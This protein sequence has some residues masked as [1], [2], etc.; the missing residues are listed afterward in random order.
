M[1]Q[2]QAQTQGGERDDNT[3]RAAVHEQAPPTPHPTPPSRTHHTHTCA[4][5]QKQTSQ[6]S[7]LPHL[8]PKV[9]QGA[10]CVTFGTFGEGA[11]LAAFQRGTPPH[12]TPHPGARHNNP[13]KSAAEVAKHQAEWGGGKRQRRARASG[14]W[15]VG[16]AGG[17]TGFP[18]TPCCPAPMPPLPTH[19]AHTPSCPTTAPPRTSGRLCW[20]PSGETQQRWRSR[21]REQARER[22]GRSGGGAARQGGRVR[23]QGREHTQQGVRHGEGA[24][25]RA[26]GAH[27][28]SGTRPQRCMLDDVHGCHRLQ[29]PG[30]GRGSGR[31]QG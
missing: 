2:G 20:T 19:Q 12:H 17:T 31:T 21:R 7:P 26:T 18:T 13:G 3:Q 14:G 25:A 4:Q 30:S 23:G 16:G 9:R 24:R 27:A 11:Q 28:A 6:S 29:G 15:R 8:R 5:E 22:E 10:R 1:G